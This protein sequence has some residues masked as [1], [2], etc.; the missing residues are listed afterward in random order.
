M[1][2]DC[3]FHTVA[4]EGE[5]GNTIEGYEA[6]RNSFNVVS[7]TSRCSLERPLSTLCAATARV[8]ESTFS[9]TNPD[10]TVIEAR[11]VDVFT[12]PERGQPAQK[13]PPQNDAISF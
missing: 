12:P 4:G 10:Y 3:V 9:A 11:M 5:L 8:S 1:T 7:R 13:R 2:E 6:V